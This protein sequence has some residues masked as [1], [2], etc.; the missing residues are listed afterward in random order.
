MRRL[1]GY[2]GGLAWR[3]SHEH[4]SPQSTTGQEVEVDRLMQRSAS[5]DAAADVGNPWVEFADDGTLLERN[6][7][8]EIEDVNIFGDD[9]ADLPWLEKQGLLD[10]QVGCYGVPPSVTDACSDDDLLE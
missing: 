5:I 2:N 4:F 3:L 9:F 7:A 10:T 1:Q 6:R 8:L